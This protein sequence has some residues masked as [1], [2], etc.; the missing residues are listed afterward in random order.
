MLSHSAA[1]HLR[2]SHRSFYQSGGALL[3]MIP[4]TLFPCLYYGIRPLLIVLCGIVSAMAT[5]LLCCVF[6]RRRPTLADGSAAVTG[7]LIGAMMSPIV[8]FWVPIVGSAFAIGVAKMPF[9]G[10]G[11]HIFNPA[12]AGAAFCAICFPTRMFVYPDPAQI[13]TLPLIDTSTVIAAV[14]P[15]QQLQ[16]GGSTSLGW[17]ALLSGDFPGPIGSVGVLIL[18]AS[19]LY[20]FTRHSSSLVI[21]VP[22]LATCAIIAAMFPRA[23]VSIGTSVQLELCTGL[24]LFCGV[25]LLSDP[26]NAPRFGLARVVYGILAG[27]VVMILRWYGRFESCEFFA[28]LLVNSFAPILDRTCWSWWR[29]LRRKGGARS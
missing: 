3:C 23:A 25:F 28:I 7:A 2:E 22:Y 14:S 19:A 17:M 24:L 8:P 18:L 11:R 16:S 6:A 9:G 20:L 4:L 13:A 21:L 1:P 26:V 15:M 29:H 27:I 5:E 10:N 12:A